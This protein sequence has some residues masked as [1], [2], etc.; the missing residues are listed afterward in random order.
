MLEFDPVTKDMFVSVRDKLFSL[1]ESP[2]QQSRFV[3]EALLV[4]VDKLETLQKTASVT[5]NYKVNEL[6]TML[7]DNGSSVSVANIDHIIVTLRKTGDGFLH[8][9][10]AFPV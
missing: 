9:V 5:I 4:N 7:I 3:H 10:T 8:V 2:E 6:A 1:F